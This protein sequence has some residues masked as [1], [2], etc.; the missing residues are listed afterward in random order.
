MTHAGEEEYLNFLG[1]GNKIS[2]K[3]GRAFKPTI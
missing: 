3:L 1:G 2:A